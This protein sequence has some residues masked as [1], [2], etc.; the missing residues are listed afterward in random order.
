MENLW[1]KWVTLIEMDYSNMNYDKTF[2]LNRNYQTTKVKIQ[3]IKCISFQSK[4]RMQKK[5]L[6]ASTN[7]YITLW[8]L[9][10]LNFIAFKT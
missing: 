10:S 8:K 9:S 7:D 4:I 2:L 1:Q 3:A 6:T 5:Y